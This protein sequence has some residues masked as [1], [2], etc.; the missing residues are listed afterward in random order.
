[1]FFSFLLLDILCLNF[2]CLCPSYYYFTVS[3]FIYFF[4]AQLPNFR[5]LDF[6]SPTPACP[7]KSPTAK[8]QPLF[9]HFIFETKQVCIYLK[10]PQ[11]SLN[12]AV[13]TN[14]PQQS[15]S[16]SSCSS[17]DVLTQVALHWYIQFPPIFFCHFITLCKHHREYTYTHIHEL[18]WWGWQ[19]FFFFFFQ[20]YFSSSIN[21][22]K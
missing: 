15:A 4:S 14:K 19:A 2:L 17:Q 6:L 18:A 13:P 3:L 5:H 8:S 16:S 22:N 9:C 21:I 20:Y 11:Y 12:S 1:M 10:V 7:Q